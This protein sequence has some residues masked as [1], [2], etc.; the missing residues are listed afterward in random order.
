MEALVDLKRMPL[1]LKREL[2]FVYH[3]AGYSTQE[4]ADRLGVKPSAVD[5]WSQADKWASREEDFVGRLQETVDEMAY[6]VVARKIELARQALDVADMAL[7]MV[8][9]ELGE[10]LQGKEIVRA[11]E[12]VSSVIDKHTRIADTLIEIERKAQLE[13]SQGNELIQTLEAA[14]WDFAE[15]DEEEE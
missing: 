8:R 4:I 11:L 7:Q 10:G 15:D 6:H 9:Q 2:A 3:L 12:V 5:S 14:E 13:G 1:K